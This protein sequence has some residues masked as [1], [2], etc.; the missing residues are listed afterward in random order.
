[1]KGG[2]MKDFTLPDISKDEAK[3]LLLEEIKGGIQYCHRLKFR[4]Q[5]ARIAGNQVAL[6]SHTKDLEAS[7]ALLAGLQEQL[8]ELEKETAP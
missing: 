6:D 1:M 8:S 3:A 2:L 5:A 4:A 7:M